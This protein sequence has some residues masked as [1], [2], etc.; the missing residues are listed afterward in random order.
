MAQYKDFFDWVK[1]QGGHINPSVDLFGVLPH[2]SRGIAATAD[3]PQGDVLILMPMKACIH[4][5]TEEKVHPR[6]P[7]TLITT[8]C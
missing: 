6:S 7:A 5:I 8:L 3:I 1:L 4:A 2:G